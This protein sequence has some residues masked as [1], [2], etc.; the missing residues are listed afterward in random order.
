MNVISRIRSF[1]PRQLRSSRSSSLDT[2]LRSRQDVEYCS[3]VRLSDGITHYEILGQDDD[4]LVVL[5]HGLTSPMFVWYYQIKPLLRSGYRVLR[6]DLYGR[7]LSDRPD[8]R[9]NAELFHRQL[10]EL[11]GRVAS[12][13][14]YG[15]I[16]LSLGGAISVGA[17]AR[18]EVDPK[19]MLLIAP[20]GLRSSMPWWFYLSVLPGVLEAYQ[21]TVG[22]WCWTS[23]GSRNLSDDPTKQERARYYLQR[24]L[25]FPGFHRALISTIRHG[26]IYGRSIPVRALWSRCDAVV[27]SE[28]HR[29]LETVLPQVEVR[30]LREGRHTVNYD[31]PELV[32]PPMMDFLRKSFPE[33]RVPPE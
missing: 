8:C 4:P 3:F 22:G 27:P 14:P 32:N 16:G 11:L 15:L 10:R 6:Y 30:L 17:T 25:K 33:S 19:K 28:L 18:A 20:A 21:Y 2:R 23:L 24:Q 26:P 13:S 31:R 29:D 12:T 5:V 9:Y 7:G 1:L